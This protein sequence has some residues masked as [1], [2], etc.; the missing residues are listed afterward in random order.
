MAVAVWHSLCS[1]RAFAS[2][3]GRRGFALVTFAL[4]LRIC[5]GAVK[6]SVHFLFW[7]GA[8]HYTCS[9]CVAR[10]AGHKFVFGG[11]GFTSS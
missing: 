11:R 5:L 4:W 9:F 6:E 7:G 10:W 8:A 3:R 1:S 2:E